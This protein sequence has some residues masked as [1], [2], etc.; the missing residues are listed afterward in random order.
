MLCA[1]RPCP[2]Q[3]NSYL[4]RQC[5]RALRALPPA[6]LHKRPCR[7]Q[8]FCVVRIFL[9]PLFSRTHSYPACVCTRSSMNI[10][11]W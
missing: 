2:W 3:G 8:V 11:I 9:K 7:N 5:Q 4:P 1:L 10:L 6:P